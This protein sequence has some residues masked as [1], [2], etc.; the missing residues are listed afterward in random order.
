MIR[1]LTAVEIIDVFTCLY[2]GYEAVVIAYSIVYTIDFDAKV[3][4]II[5]IDVLSMHRTSKAGSK[6]SRSRRAGYS[7]GSST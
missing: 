5:I 6:R 3:Q 4:I 7:T 2:S 1:R